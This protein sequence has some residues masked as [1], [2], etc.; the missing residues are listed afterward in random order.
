MSDGGDVAV[1][2]SLKGTLSHLSLPHSNSFSPSALMK[3][4][5]ASPQ[6]RTDGWDVA[7]F[8]SLKRTLSHSDSFPAVLLKFLN[9]SESTGED[10]WLGHGYNLFSGGDS[11][12]LHLLPCLGV[13]SNEIPHCQ[14][15]Q[16]RG[17]TART[18]WPNKH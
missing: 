10:L 5:N 14:R 17:L 13:C 7:T 16:K 12:P 4:F 18:P 6:E 15:V 11:H 8:C 9:L 3:S 2:Y 1:I